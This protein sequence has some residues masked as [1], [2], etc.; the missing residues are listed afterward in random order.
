[1]INFERG[2]LLYRKA[3]APSI[4]TLLYAFLPHKFVDHT[5]STAILNLTN[6]PNGEELCR[7]V[8]GDRAGLVPYIKPGFDLA[9]KTVEV[10]ESNKDVDALIALKHGI[11]TYGKTAHD[12]YQRMIDAVT[13]VE[14]RLEQGRKGVFATGAVPVKTLSLVEVAPIVRGACST[15]DGGNISAILR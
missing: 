9:K 2:N 6:Q 15:K 12:A 8:F 10:F 11:F 4:E 13:K 3:P 1:M 5:H 14:R 7:E